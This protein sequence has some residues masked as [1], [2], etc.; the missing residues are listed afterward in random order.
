M[1]LTLK[2]TR[3]QKETQFCATELCDHFLGIMNIFPDVN[4]SFF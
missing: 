2:L 3:R 1:V 4:F